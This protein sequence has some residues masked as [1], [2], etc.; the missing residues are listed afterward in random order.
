MGD[1]GAVF[2]E[3]RIERLAHA[4]QPLEFE[5]ALVRCQS[6]DGRDRQCIVGG[7]LRKNPRP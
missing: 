5:T 6:E 1:V 4:V 7:E 2:A 3:L